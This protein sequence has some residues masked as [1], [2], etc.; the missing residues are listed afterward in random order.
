MEEEEVDSDSDSEEEDLA[1]PSLLT[2][3]INSYLSSYS[4]KWLLKR[5]H[6]YKNQYKR[7]RASLK[8]IKKKYEE[9]REHNTMLVLKL[10]AGSSLPPLEDHGLV[11]SWSN[12]EIKVIMCHFHYCFNFLILEYLT[13]TNFHTIFMQI[14]IENCTER[15]MSGESKT[16]GQFAHKEEL[17]AMM[18]KIL[19]VKS[20]EDEDFSTLM[21]QKTK[22]ITRALQL[23][24]GKQT[25]KLRKEFFKLLDFE[26]P[27]DDPRL[28]TVELGRIREDFIKNCNNFYSRNANGK[29]T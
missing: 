29:Q 22:T 15:C 21:R 10:A 9:L 4:K 6:K 28:S 24:R 11:S 14:A 13:H 17:A 8:Q 26:E 2:H 20:N 1:S 3:P 18:R 16:A 27:V 19:A 5:L 12:M 7:A 23:A 25:N